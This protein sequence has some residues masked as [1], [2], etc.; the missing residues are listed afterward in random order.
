VLGELAAALWG[1]AGGS[2]FGAGEWQTY[3]LAL[4][5][6]LAVTL[7]P[8]LAGVVITSRIDPTD[9]LRGL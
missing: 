6:A 2:G 9:T 1:A 7:V 8:S 5:V 4:A 3:G